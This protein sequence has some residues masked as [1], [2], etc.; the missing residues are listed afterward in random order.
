[1]W[2]EIERFTDLQKLKGLEKLHKGMRYDPLPA[3]EKIEL[4]NHILSKNY[5]ILSDGVNIM[6]WDKNHDE[7][8]ADAG[9]H[10]NLSH[11]IQ[12]LLNNLSDQVHAN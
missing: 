11:Y 1:M 8:I 3:T 5:K 12:H 2:Q 4:I 9:T 10:I 7:V 6:I